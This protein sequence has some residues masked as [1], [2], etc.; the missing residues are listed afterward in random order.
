MCCFLFI[1]IRL[2]RTWEKRDVSP[3][4]PSNLPVP[5]IAERIDLIRKLSK[6]FIRHALTFFNNGNETFSR[7]HQAVKRAG[8]CTVNTLC[9]FLHKLSAALCDLF[10]GKQIICIPTVGS[11]SIKSHIV[12]DMF[13]ELYR[14]GFLAMYNK[15]FLRRLLKVCNPCSQMIPVRMPADTRKV[16]NACSDLNFLS[17]KFYLFTPFNRE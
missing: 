9:L 5:L 17:E 15:H 16:Y 4:F 2:F 13:R 7:N 8:F 6:I 3:A 12:F 14:G 11:Q 10:S 1:F